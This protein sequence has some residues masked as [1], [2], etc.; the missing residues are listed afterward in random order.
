M[1][2]KVEHYGDVTEVRLHP[3]SKKT[4][5]WNASCGAIGIAGLIYMKK[6]W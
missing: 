5:I 6:N 1:K 3:D 2:F 4:L